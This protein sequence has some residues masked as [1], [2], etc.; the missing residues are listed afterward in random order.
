M[1]AFVLTRTC[2][3]GVETEPVAWQMPTFPLMDSARQSSA[4]I[5]L[6]AS[7]STPSVSPPFARSV[8]Q[9]VG[10]KHAPKHAASVPSTQER[11]LEAQM[12]PGRDD[13]ER[14]M[15]I[16]CLSMNASTRARR[17]REPEIARFLYTG[18]RSGRNERYGALGPKYG[19]SDM[20]EAVARLVPPPMPLCPRIWRCA[21]LS[22]A[23]LTWPAT[24]GRP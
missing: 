24:A 3:N 13:T 15:S 18:Q 8:V 6:A 9:P 20:M 23:P 21:H 12:P 16:G 5:S 22:R 11:A 1:H 7:V 19:A 10:N 2:T 4:T 17:T 14:W